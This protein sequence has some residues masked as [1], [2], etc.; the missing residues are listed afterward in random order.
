M[1]AK[2]LLSLA[3]DAGIISKEAYQDA[4]NEEQRQRAGRWERTELKCT[5]EGGE[6][7]YGFM[8]RKV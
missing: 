1:D 7:V 4:K 3:D 6:I 5:T 8:E 2:K